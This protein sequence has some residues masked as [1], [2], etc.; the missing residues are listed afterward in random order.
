MT[1]GTRKQRGQEGE[2]LAAQIIQ[3]NGLKILVR[4][5][6]CPVGEMD[7]IALEDEKLIFIE[8]RTR[9]TPKFGWGEESIQAKKRMRLQR[10]AEYFIL[11][12]KYKEWPPLRFDLIA[13]RWDEKNP[14]TNWIRGI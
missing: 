5:F 4:N 10:I 14:Q 6:R 13:I 2:D 8:V 1:A 9:S 12:R 11:S 7:I 3:S